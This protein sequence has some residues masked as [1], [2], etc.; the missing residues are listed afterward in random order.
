MES[1]SWD[2]SSHDSSTIAGVW[3]CRIGNGHRQAFDETAAQFFSALDR[4]GTPAV[5]EGREK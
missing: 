4:R 5:P 1:P 2:W 3:G